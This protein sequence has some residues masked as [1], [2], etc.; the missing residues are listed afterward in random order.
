MHKA[1]IFFLNCIYHPSLI[2]FCI[3]PI[4]VPMRALA[5][6]IQGFQ[7]VFHNAYERLYF[8]VDMVS[9]V[10]LLGIIVWFVVFLTTKFNKTT[11]QDDAIT[12]IGWFCPFAL[13]VTTYLLLSGHYSALVV[14]AA[15]GAHFYLLRY[16]GVHVVLQMKK[17]KL[18]GEHILGD[19]IKNNLLSFM[20]N[21][22]GTIVTILFVLASFYHSL[23]YFTLSTSFLGGVY[24]YFRYI[25]KKIHHFHLK[26]LLKSII[27]FAIGCILAMLVG[28][29]MFAWHVFSSW[30][31]L[32]SFLIVSFALL[33]QVKPRYVLMYITGYG[34]YALVL[35]TIMAS[36]I[37]FFLSSV[38]PKKLYD[39]LYM[40][41]P[42]FSLLIVI[43]YLIGLYKSQNKIADKQIV[44]NVYKTNFLLII[45]AISLL[46]L[47]TQS[48]VLII[49]GLI[50]FLLIYSIIEYRTQFNMMQIILINHY[51]PQTNTLLSIYT[52]IIRSGIIPVVFFGVL[53]L[54]RHNTQMPFGLEVLTAI[55]I[56]TC[57]LFIFNWISLFILQKRV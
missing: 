47:I 25:H 48:L 17:Y 4:Y 11:S 45:F 18:Q 24:F 19:E 43:V 27:P 41:E 52:E 29:M 26:A 56:I 28:I 44:H 38:A 57:V 36:L 5:G 39:S 9:I 14:Y 55:M 30:L 23:L 34:Q 50:G 1:K 15:M 49:V 7:V 40:L 33:R 53:S 21:T 2:Y 10:A 37:L 42:V 54:L 13:M 32:L 16:L 22:L 35:L 6:N 31:I 20:I 46:V 3:L 12:L 51:N 8:F